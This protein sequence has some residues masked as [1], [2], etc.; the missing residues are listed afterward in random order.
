MSEERASRDIL[1]PIDFSRA[2]AAALETARAIRRAQGGGITAIHVVLP[3]THLD[4]RPS[5]T[6][7]EQAARL[8]EARELTRAFLTEQGMDD[9]DVIAAG[10]D[11]AREITDAAAKMEAGLIVMPAHGKNWMDRLVVGSVTERTVR[12]ARCPVLVIPPP[13]RAE[14]APKDWAA[15]SRVIVPF[16]F[17]EHDLRALKYARRFVEDDAQLTAVHVSPIPSPPVLEAI[18]NPFDPRASAE[19]ARVAVQAQL[20]AHGLA[21]A[22]AHARLGLVGPELLHAAETENA[23]LVVVASHGRSGLGR[24][25]IGSVAEGLVRHAPS[26][27]LVLHFDDVNT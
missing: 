23:E 10:G 25:L 21:H 2:G 26:P 9:V 24:M 4:G 16:D 1:V 15:V 7:S 19:R 3:P 20:E 8:L 13:I 27:V 6:E 17:T 18:W 12:F 11:P 22:K 14:R 5:W